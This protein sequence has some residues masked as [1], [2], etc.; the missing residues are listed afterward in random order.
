MKLSKSIVSSP[1]NANHDIS[2]ILGEIYSDSSITMDSQIHENKHQILIA[3][4]GVAGIFSALEILSKFPRAYVKVI[5]QKDAILSGT[6]ANTPGRMGLG[7]H[8]KDFETALQYMINTLNFMKKYND[9]FIEDEGMPNLVNGRYFILKNSIVDPQELMATY[10]RLSLEF[11]KLWMNDPEIQKLFPETCHLHRTIHPSKYQDYVDPKMVHLAIETREK[12]LDWNKFVHKVLLQ[13][14]EYIKKG[15]AEIITSTEVVGIG[16]DEDSN[17]RIE[18]HKKTP[19]GKD[20][21]FLQAGIFI[22][23]TWQ[24]AENLDK[25]FYITSYLDWVARM[26]FLGEIKIP[27]SLV[28]A[29]SMFF[30]LGPFAM[31]SNMGVQRDEQGQSL[32]YSL[33]RI[34]YAEVTNHSHYPSTEMPDLY[35]RLLENRLTEDDIRLLDERGK[36]IVEGVAKYIPKIAEAELVRVLPGIVK[37]VGE[38]NIFDPNSKFHERREDGIEELSSDYIKNSAIKLFYCLSNAEKLVE[39]MQRSMVTKI[40]IN[41]LLKK[42]STN[43]FLNEQ[44]KK[45]M[46]VFLRIYVKR[47]LYDQFNDLSGDLIQQV[48]KKEDLVSQEQQGLISLKQKKLLD[49]FFKELFLDLDK[50]KSISGLSE[51][52]NIANQKT[53]VKELYGELLSV[54]KNKNK[55]FEELKRFYD[56]K[57]FQTREREVSNLKPKSIQELY[58]QSG[59]FDQNR[60][61]HQV[62]KGLRG[63]RVLSYLFDFGNEVKDLK[64]LKDS[65]LDL[66]EKFKSSIETLSSEGDQADYIENKSLNFYDQQIL[67]FYKEFLLKKL[68]QISFEYREADKIT[69]D[70]YDAR[71]SKKILE[72][73]S[74][75]DV[76][77]LIMDI[78]NKDVKKTFLELFGI[79]LKDFNKT[80]ESFVVAS[81]RKDQD[82]RL[83][84]LFEDDNKKNIQAIREREF[85]QDFNIGQFLNLVRFVVN[86]LKV[87]LNKESSA[88]QSSEEIEKAKEDLLKFKLQEYKDVLMCEVIDL[89]YCRKIKNNSIDDYLQGNSREK[90]QQGPSLNIEQKLSLEISC[91]I[92]ELVFENNSLDEMRCFLKTLSPELTMAQ[93]QS[94]NNEQCIFELDDLKYPENQEKLQ[95]LKK[96]QF[97]EQILSQYHELKDNVILDIV[98]SSIEN[99]ASSF[100]RPNEFKLTKSAEGFCQDNEGSFSRT[101]SNV[102]IFSQDSTGDNWDDRSDASTRQGSP[103]PGNSPTKATVSPNSSCL[104]SRLSKIDC[105]KI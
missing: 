29:H 76:L 41:H 105:S 28:D 13:L 75:L 51:I 18:L 55:L 4:A 58:D 35:R 47:Y 102:S 7:Y 52:K 38:V 77:E 60:D 71:S 84:N 62:Q 94:R 39:I 72:R 1:K 96:H 64:K 45:H 17:F 31:F 65:F 59:Y 68:P 19:Q 95:S 88:E 25:K 101:S 46:L 14:D 73:S 56:P 93:D 8:Y 30:C 11:E 63:N 86:K 3:G 81:G 42:F 85:D 40:V 79:F 12:L 36:K 10:D 78:D 99:V 22:N 23:A 32:G 27:E 26:K 97:I 92:Y 104:A 24:N 74:C 103:F 66:I 43:S 48:F 2:E 50:S 82:Y 98:S 44:Q 61:N 6:S 83:I 89:E 70:Q 53:H 91:K 16:Y 87:D 57:Y 54:F 90:E 69:S 20:K 37:S 34:T 5:E 80:M 49:D 21:I 9:C 15:R 100:A 67:K 33:A